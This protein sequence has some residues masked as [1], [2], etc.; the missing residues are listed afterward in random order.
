MIMMLFMLFLAL[1]MI[2]MNH[3]ISMSMIL[4]IQTIMISLMTGLMKMNFWYSYILFLIMI[5]GLLIL[6][7]YMTSIASNE[8]F[9]FSFNLNLIFIPLMIIF[10]MN[11]IFPLKYN[12][13]YYTNSLNSPFNYIMDLNKFFNYP[14]NI[15][16]ILMIIYLFLGLIVVVKITNFKM[17]TL[18]QKF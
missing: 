15:L 2:F 5:G 14:L 16:M 13:L 9:K 18:R 17:G 11:I 12:L 10:S 3:P 4:L 1:F 6:F 8:K 7:M